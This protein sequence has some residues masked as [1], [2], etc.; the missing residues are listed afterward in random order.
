MRAVYRVEW[1]DEDATFIVR[2]YLDGSAVVIEKDRL[3]G[4][5]VWDHRVNP[6][7]TA[8]VACD[9]WIDEVRKAIDDHLRLGRERA[10]AQQRYAR[11]EGARYVSC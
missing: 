6:T 8:D 2:V 1:A 7:E 5:L 4:A 11:V 3:S 10:K 9:H